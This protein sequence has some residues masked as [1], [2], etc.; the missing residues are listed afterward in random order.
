MYVT[1]PQWSEPFWNMCDLW[2]GQKTAKCGLLNDPIDW[3]KL[4]LN[5][6]KKGRGVKYFKWKHFLKKAYRKFSIVHSAGWPRFIWNAFNLLKDACTITHW[7]TITKRVHFHDQIMKMKPIIKYCSQWPFRTLVILTFF[8]ANHTGEL[9]LFI[10][11]KSTELNSITY[12]CFSSYVLSGTWVHWIY[13][14]RIK[15]TPQT[16][17][18]KNKGKSTIHTF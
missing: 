1:I 9:S 17:E 14:C 2:S 12:W 7:W 5:Q 11:R 8:G 6:P 10:F 15:C 13:S 16:T 4:R 18:N 3:S